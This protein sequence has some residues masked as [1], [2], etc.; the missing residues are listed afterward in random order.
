MGKW[1]QKQN[2]TQTSLVSSGKEVY[3]LIRIPS[4]EVA[5]LVFPN[6][7]KGWISW[8]YSE[9]NVSTEENIDVAVAAYVTKQ[10]LLK[11]YEYLRK[12][13]KYVIM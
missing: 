2:K 10:A 1:A 6:D 8:K 11:L 9:E 13:G 12:F 7:Y 4:I 3:K 5:N